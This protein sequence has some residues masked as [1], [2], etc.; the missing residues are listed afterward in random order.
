MLGRCLACYKKKKVRSRS[1]YFRICFV[2]FHS[3]AIDNMKKIQFFNQLWQAKH[4]KA[5]EGR[6]MKFLICGFINGS[7]SFVFCVF[8][9]LELTKHVGIGE[10][11]NDCMR[12]A[13]EKVA[14]GNLIATLICQRFKFELRFWRICHATRKLAK[15][16]RSHRHQKLRSCSTQLK[17]LFFNQSQI[18]LNFSLTP[19]WVAQFAQNSLVAKA[20]KSM[21]RAFYRCLTQKLINFLLFLVFLRTNHSSQANQATRPINFKSHYAWL[22]FLCPGL[23]QT[24]N[25]PAEF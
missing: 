25:S 22:L 1:W 24:S 10:H 4:I 20:T 9:G 8:L 11:S 16:R 6:F 17:F 15:T 21:S 18:H 23:S 5:V 14:V 2:R 19:N 13:Y 3:L 7:K 12:F